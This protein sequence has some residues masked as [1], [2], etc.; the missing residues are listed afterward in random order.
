MGGVCAVTS[1]LT[2]LFPNF[3]EPNGALH[4]GLSLTPHAPIAAGS[5]LCAVPFSQKLRPSCSFPVGAQLADGGHCLA[6]FGAAA[7]IGSLLK[8]VASP[9]K[10]AVYSVYYSAGIITG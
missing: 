7:H 9:L 4:G 5:C 3:D 10:S 1:C 2:P 8:P 6:P